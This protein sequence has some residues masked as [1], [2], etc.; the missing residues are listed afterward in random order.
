[1]NIGFDFTGGA[2]YNVYR[3]GLTEISME[4][5]EV[6]D[7]RPIASRNSSWAGRAAKYLQRKGA[8]PNGISVASIVFAGLAGG[9][10]AMGFYFS[11]LVSGG[12]AD[13]WGIVRAG[14]FDL[15]SA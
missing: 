12:V 14:A 13:C 7:R 9:C 3:F 4:E 8:T 11:P 15:Q 2:N 10:F 6:K 1:M 5:E